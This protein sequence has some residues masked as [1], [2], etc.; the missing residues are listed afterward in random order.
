MIKLAGATPVFLPCRPETA[1]ALEPEAVRKAL[2][3]R[4]TAFWWLF[5]LDQTL[6]HLT[7][8]GLA[9]LL[10]AGSAA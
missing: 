7:H 1:F 2:T 8:I 5:G 9:I 10:A 3:P 6:H 4:Q